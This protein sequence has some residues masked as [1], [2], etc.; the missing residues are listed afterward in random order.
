M[1]RDT[2]NLTPQ[3]IQDLNTALFEQWDAKTRDMQKMAEKA[4]VFYHSRSQRYFSI[5]RSCDDR[6]N[7]QG[8]S[9]TQELASHCYES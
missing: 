8:I 4:N 5:F 1:M 2:S 7:V 9:K 6:G 3:Q